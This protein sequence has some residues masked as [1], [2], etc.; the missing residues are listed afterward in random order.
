MKTAAL[1]NLGCKTNAYETESMAE[2]LKA[3]GYTIVP[4]SEKAD[5]YVINTCSVTAVADQKSRQMISRARRKN[6]EAIVVAAGCYVQTG[7]EKL[8]ADKVADIIIGNNKKNE[9]VD[10]IHRFMEER[11][12]IE[13]V[14]D[15]NAGQMDFEDLTMHASDDHSR[16]FLK[17]QDG[18]NQFCS[19]C[20]IPYARGRV[21]CRSKQSILDEVRRLATEGYQEVVLT[22]IH[23]TSYQTSEGNLIDLVEDMAKIPGITRIRLG[24]LEPSAV[25]EEFAKRL[26]EVD[27]LCPHFHMSLQSGCDTVLARMNRHYTTEEFLESCRLL[28]E[29]F[30]DPALTTDIIC[31]FP[32]ESE[33]EFLQTLSFVEKIGFYEIHI[34]PYSVRQGTRAQRMSG[35]ITKKVKHERC[36]RLREK[37]EHLK[38]EYLGRHSGDMREILLEDQQMIGDTLCWMGYTK[39]YIRCYIPVGELENHYSGDAVCGYLGQENAEGIYRLV[40]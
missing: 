19:Y 35:Q 11:S 9:L 32:G 39:E 20:I 37:A 4:F 40:L 7:K 33:D 18:C 30:H 14:D 36:A 31:G 22:G 12:V 3:D 34:F 29:Y 16:A 25:T 23:I 6:K 24:S 1:H 21:R 38:Q 8:L 13:D 26:S 10:Q 28:K 15:I 27:V 5:V 2:M 17:I